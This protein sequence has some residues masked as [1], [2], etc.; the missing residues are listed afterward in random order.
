MQV[1]S[2]TGV[3]VNRR[4]VVKLYRCAGLQLYR[5]AVVRVWKCKGLQLYRCSGVQVCRCWGVQ[6]CRCQ[7]PVCCRRPNTEHALHTHITVRC[8]HKCWPMCRCDWAAV[9]HR[10]NPDPH[11]FVFVCN[12]KSG[13]SLVHIAFLPRAV[14]FTTK[15]ARARFFRSHCATP[16][17]LYPLLDS[18]YNTRYVRDWHLP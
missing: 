10:S 4:E 13:N 5:C 18:L 11:P 12:Y 16:N 3:Q 2:C 1:Y 15:G 7:W 8:S 17:C 6:V 14:R 9:E